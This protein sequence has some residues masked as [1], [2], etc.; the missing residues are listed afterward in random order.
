MICRKCS[1]EL[2]AEAVFCMLCGAKQEVTQKRKGKRGNGQGSVYKLPSGRYRASVVVASYKNGDGKIVQKRVVRNFMTKKEAIAALPTLARNTKPTDMTLHELYETYKQGKD[3]NA[4]S[5][6]Q[7]NKL[8]Y[9]WRRLAPLEFRGIVGITVDDMQTVIDSATT[10]F[11]PARDMKVLLSHLYK[12][13]IKKEIVPYNKTDNIDLPDAPKAKRECWT[14]NEIQAMWSDYKT[15]TF[16]A[17]PLIMCY[18]GLRYGEL[19]KLPLENIHLDERY[20]IGGIKSEAGIDRE[21][22]I[23]KKIVPLIETCMSERKDKL[24]EMSEDNFY[25]AYWSMVERTGIRHLPPHTC[26]HYYFSSMTAA[27]VQGGLIAEVGGHANY[28]T[29]LKNYVRVPLSDKI[30]A[31]DVIE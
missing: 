12:L 15:N 26:R 31:V 16:T 21:I 5:D 2:P 29:T 9:A 19:A 27:G 4:V 10:T 1:A 7:K 28:L 24:L 30:A 22:P 8:L 25:S 23:H 11:Y 3:Y 14:A 20:M 6:S 13:A 17:Y 18:A